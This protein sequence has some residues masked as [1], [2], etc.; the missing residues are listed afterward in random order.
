MR[1]LESQMAVA[2]P[3]KLDSILKTYGRLQDQ[4]I[5]E[6]G[7][8]INKKVGKI[9]N[10]F[11][12]FD[13]LLER[14]F[15]SLSGGEKTIINLASFIISESEILLLDEP[16]NHIDINTKDVLEAALTALSGTIAGSSVQAILLIK[17]QTPEG[18]AIYIQRSVDALYKQLE[19]RKNKQRYEF[20][21]KLNESSLAD[22]QFA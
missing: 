6:G 7:Y 1:K 5:N 13:D 14:N 10:G 19:K 20:T 9:C 17:K 3:E 8:E 15:N 12:F 2:N 18:Q 16:T 21:Q 22:T 11:K 4:F